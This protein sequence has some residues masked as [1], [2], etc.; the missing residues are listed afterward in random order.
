MGV[1]F[2]V[3][4][5]AALATLMLAPQAL[6]APAGRTTSDVFWFSN[7]MAE[8]GASSTL[9]R[10]DSGV[11]AT[12]HTSGLSPGDAV[13]TWWVIFNHPAECTEG[14]PPFRCAEGDLFNPAVEASV[15][16]AAGRPVGGN[17]SYNVASYISEGDSG[18]P[19]GDFLCAG[20]IDSREADVHLVVRTH[21][22]ALQE[23]LPE[24][25]MTFG[26]ACGNV[27]PELGG[28]G[29]NTCEDLQFAVH[30]TI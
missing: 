14:E 16:Y 30:E 28:G 27:P 1:K 18:C 15:Q 23:F 29:P 9:I 12:V 8:P 7:G 13:T 21:G 19:F 24:Q 10:T 17:G 26:G 25:F 6:A 2:R 3:L 20:L 5:F 22:P 11:S 4:L